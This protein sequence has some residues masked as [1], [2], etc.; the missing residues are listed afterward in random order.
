MVSVRTVQHALAISRI[1]KH[2]EKRFT[3]KIEC[4]YVVNLAFGCMSS[5][6]SK[7]KFCSNPENN[8]KV[9]R[10]FVLKRRLPGFFYLNA[11]LL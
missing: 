5:K 8:L 9:L 7:E 2:L 4:R 11:V 1:P 6:R 10:N 3:F